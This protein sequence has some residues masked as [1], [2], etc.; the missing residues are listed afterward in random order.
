MLGTKALA[1]TALL[2][3]VFLSSGYSL[4]AQNPS[5][6]LAATGSPAVRDPSGLAVIERAIS[7]AGGSALVKSIAD[8]DAKGTITYHWAD[9]DVPG[10]VEIK[11][12]GLDQVSGQLSAGSALPDVT[13]AKQI[14]ESMVA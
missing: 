8:F 1:P 7:V 13:I 12:R 5:L 9:Q 3:I 4:F 11:A 6:N 14:R 10:Q 2:A